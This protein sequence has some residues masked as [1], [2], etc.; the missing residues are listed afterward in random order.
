VGFAAVIAPT[1]AFMTPMEGELKQSN[2]SMAKIW[3]A[4]AAL[5]MVLAVSF[6][7]SAD[8]GWHRRVYPPFYRIYPPY[9]WGYPDHHLGRVFPMF[10]ETVVRRVGNY[11]YRDTLY[12]YQAPP[13]WDC[14]W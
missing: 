6:T 4:V 11:Y 12:Y 13:Y 9:P 14:C 3:T 2:M 10:A 7:D 1:G 5:A 8:A